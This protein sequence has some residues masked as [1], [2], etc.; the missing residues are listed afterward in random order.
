NLHI[1]VTDAAGQYAEKQFGI[2][3]MVSGAA[4]VTADENSNT[5]YKLQ[6]NFENHSAGSFE[7]VNVTVATTH[8][9]IAMITGTASLPLL[10][11]GQTTAL[12]DLIKFSINNRLGNKEVVSFTVNLKGAG[13]NQTLYIPVTITRPE[14]NLIGYRVDDGHNNRLDPGETA[15]VE[16]T[17]ANVSDISLDHLRMK[18]ISSD[19]MLVVSDTAYTDPVIMNPGQYMKHAF[20]VNSSRA[21]EEGSE[22]ILTV[23]IADTTGYKQRFLITLTVGETVVLIADAAVQSNTADT[24]EKYFNLMRIPTRTVKSAVVDYKATAIFLLLGSQSNSYNLGAEEGGRYAGYLST[25]KNLYLEGFNYWRYGIKSI[26]NKCLKYTAVTTPVSRYDSLAGLPDNFM[27][28]KRIRMTA[29]NTVSTYTL[30]MLGNS[31]PLFESDMP[32]P[33]TIVYTKDT[34]YKIIGSMAELGNMTPVYP[35][36]MRKLISSYCSFLGLDTSGIKP[37]FHALNRRV[38]LSDTVRFKDDSFSDIATWQWEFAGGTPSVSTE[39]NPRIVYPEKGIYPVKL[40][41]WKD[42]LSRSITRENYVIVAETTGVVNKPAIADQL[43]VFPNPATD[44]ITIECPFPTGRVTL[45]WYSTDG[46]LLGSE[47]RN[48]EKQMKVRIT[49]LPAGNSVL[50]VRQGQTTRAAQVTRIR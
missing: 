34:L 35:L 5:T 41:V 19:A 24:L 40:T 10:A 30:G 27:S 36:T 48:V 3:S 25:G 38:G 22:H 26:L 13:L 37:L 23:Y 2:F 12:N 17:L 33:K 29:G 4:S 18:L 11:V 14:I 15:D 8:P 21:T 7:D 16:I 31:K 39:Q 1:R 20:T 9:G 43:L 44:C 28:G 42:G 45:E 6:L 46:A 50:V 32:V 47:Q 49:F